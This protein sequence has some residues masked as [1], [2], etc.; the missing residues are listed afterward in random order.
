MCSEL[1][2]ISS[3]RDLIFQHWF[4]IPGSIP[5]TFRRKVEDKGSGWDCSEFST[6]AGTGWAAGDNVDGSSVEGRSEEDSTVEKE[7][8]DDGSLG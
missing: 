5:W 1:D 2:V 4:L 8:V 7:L 6:V 3:Y